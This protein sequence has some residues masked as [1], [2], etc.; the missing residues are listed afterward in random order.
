MLI[1]QCKSYF[2]SSYRRFRHD[3][4]IFNFHVNFVQE[5]YFEDE[6]EVVK[7]VVPLESEV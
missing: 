7:R 1:V 4:M 3:F 6:I 5:N 2:S